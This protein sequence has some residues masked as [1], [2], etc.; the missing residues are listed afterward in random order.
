[1]EAAT[2]SETSPLIGFP[3]FSNRNALVSRAETELP[4]E[5]GLRGWLSVV[6][7]WLC[8]FSTFGFLS[9]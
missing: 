8:L 5:E 6:G 7:A 4:P 2:A 1:M 9:A 3:E